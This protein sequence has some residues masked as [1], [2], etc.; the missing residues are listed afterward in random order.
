MQLGLPVFAPL[1]V[2][3]FKSPVAVVAP[4]EV[5]FNESNNLNNFKIDF[6]SSLS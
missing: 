2:I 3:P 5:T 6:V 1:P 4:H